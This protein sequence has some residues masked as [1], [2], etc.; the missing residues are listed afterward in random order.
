MNHAIDLFGLEQ[1]IQRA[2]VSDI[3]LVEASLGMDSLPKAGEQIVRHNHIAACFD[4]FIYGVGA[5]ITSSA[6]Y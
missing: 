2:A 4:Q 5:D 1:G 6:Q 3:Q